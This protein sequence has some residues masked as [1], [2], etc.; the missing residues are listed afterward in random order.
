MTR[1]EVL[2]FIFSCESLLSFVQSQGGATGLTADERKT[3]TIYKKMLSAVIPDQ[4]E[5]H[6]EGKYKEAA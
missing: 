1:F 3:I 5:E 2:D 4:D 6:E